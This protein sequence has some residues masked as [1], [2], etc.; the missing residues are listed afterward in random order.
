MKKTLKITAIGLVIFALVAN[1]HSAMLSFYGIKNN[2]LEG[3][4]W[5]NSLSVTTGSSS[6]SGSS[7]SGTSSS[8]AVWHSP[9]YQTVQCGD[10]Q[11]SGST[12]NHGA[13]TVATTTSGTGVVSVT[14]SYASVSTSS[15]TGTVK[16][17]SAK[18]KQCD[19][20]TIDVTCWGTT[21]QEACQ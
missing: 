5:A 2:K 20:P 8:G 3:A 17:H 11:F 12:T 15:Y 18:M 9:I 10:M 14:V 13:A 16:A 6:G 4:I 7:S 19:G 1:L 21:A